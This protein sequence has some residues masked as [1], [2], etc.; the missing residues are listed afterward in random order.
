MY[1]FVNLYI[2]EN[3]TTALGKTGTSINHWAEQSSL[4][5]ASFDYSGFKPIDRTKVPCERLPED[6]FDTIT[7]NTQSIIKYNTSTRILF[8]IIKL[9]SDII[10]AS[11]LKLDRFNSLQ[12]HNILKNVISLKDNTYIAAGYCGDSTYS[13]CSIKT[14]SMTEDK[15]SI[16]PR[17]S[18]SISFIDFSDFCSPVA[19]EDS[20]VIEECPCAP[21]TTPTPTPTPPESKED[22]VISTIEDICIGDIPNI[23][24]SWIKNRSNLI[25]SYLIQITQNNTTKDEVV[26]GTFDIAANESSGSINISVSSIDTTLNRKTCIVNILDISGKTIYSKIFV[27]TI[28]NCSTTT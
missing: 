26:S 5:D 13:N 18:D 7:L 28:R 15:T 22:I 20:V 16:G 10:L 17:S 6:L 1:L 3:N 9:D 14:I 23:K 11:P 25:G 12:E 27:L 21:Q 8:G 19:F 24:F 2:T 4:F